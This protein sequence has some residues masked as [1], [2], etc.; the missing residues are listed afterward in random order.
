MNTVTSTSL[1]HLLLQKTFTGNSSRK[2]L[3]VSV[4]VS[5]GYTENLVNRKMS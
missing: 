1:A 4:R 3:V 2:S 5:S